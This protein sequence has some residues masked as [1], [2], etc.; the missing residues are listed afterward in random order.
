MVEIQ[1]L[2]SYCA[3]IIKEKEANLESADVF[4][5]SLMSLIDKGFK[6]LVVDFSDVEYVDSTFIAALVSGLKYAM[7]YNGDVAVAR[8]SKDIRHLFSL[9][10]MD[11]VFMIYDEIP[12]LFEPSF[13]R[14]SKDLN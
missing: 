12:D 13:G 14:G 1:K 8:L 5:S 11:K 6:Y 10:R 2:D 3:V 4:K 7:Q 9:I